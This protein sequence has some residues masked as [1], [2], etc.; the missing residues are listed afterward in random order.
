MKYPRHPSLLI[1]CD[2]GASGAFAVFTPQGAS[3]TL[4]LWEYCSTDDWRKLVKYEPY[5]DVAVI[6][7]NHGIQ[8]QPAGTSFTQ[9]YNQGA[10]FRTLELLVKEVIK[11]IP[12][13]WQKVFGVPKK[14]EFPGNLS[15]QTSAQ[16]KWTQTK[17]HAI[18]GQA[19]PLWASDAVAI[20]LAYLEEINHVGK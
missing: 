20:G 17:V 1:S 12:Q 5:G 18:T 19:V 13:R 14:R 6:E 9:G 3:G 8:G 11:V 10:T 15:K 4:H 16:K 7:F 2:P